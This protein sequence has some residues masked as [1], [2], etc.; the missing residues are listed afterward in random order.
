MDGSGE[1][2]PAHS[3]GQLPKKA[4]VPS[5]WEVFKHR[6]AETARG[7]WPKKPKALGIAAAVST[8]LAVPAASALYDN[9]S[10]AGA[11]VEAGPVLIKPGRVVQL[12]T[13]TSLSGLENS[14]YYPQSGSSQASVPPDEMAT[15]LSLPEAAPARA[16]ELEKELIPT[17][18]LQKH[19]IFI[20]NLPHLRFLPTRQALEDE[21]L[22][23][24]TWRLAE[25]YETDPA[26]PKLR[27]FITLVDDSRL[28]K[29][30]PVPKSMQDFYQRIV[31][32]NREEALKNDDL[33][34][35][36]DYAVYPEKGNADPRFDIK[37]RTTG[38]IRRGE[39]AL[40]YDAV[41][42]VA[43]GGGFMPKLSDSYPDSGKIT[44]KAQSVIFDLKSLTDQGYK[45]YPGKKENLG[46]L[47]RHELDHGKQFV[48]NVV[49]TDSRKGDVGGSRSGEIATDVRSAQK[50]IQEG[51]KN[52]QKTGSLSGLYI[53]FKT[54]QGMVYTM[55]EKNLGAT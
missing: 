15:A 36:F 20:N 54:P 47:L 18:E 29:N 14:G 5:D 45:Y 50:M 27:L 4:V 1:K 26:A 43:A 8:T 19:N 46:A 30:S 23:S 37:N 25:Q 28:R 2:L 3:E 38:V 55:P 10:F 41:V 9:P 32:A 12:D 16:D 7:W 48:E 11:G 35:S 52:Y 33:W 44:G 34:G 24:E 21:P 6:L 22:L 51:T 53:W 17:E 39:D 13:S 31:L 49:R 42:F 40:H